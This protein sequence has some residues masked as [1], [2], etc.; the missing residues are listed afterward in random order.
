MR[1]SGPV[2]KV[3]T[4]SDLVYYFAIGIG[5]AIVLGLITYWYSTNNYAF[6]AALFIV[7]GL[8]VTVN[9]TDDSVGD[10][11]PPMPPPRVSSKEKRKNR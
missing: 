11:P 7:I 8:R 10:S 3:K 4:S 6:I 9:G 1:E 2:L 5:I